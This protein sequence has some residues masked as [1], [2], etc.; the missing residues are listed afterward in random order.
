MKRSPRTGF[1]SEPFDVLSFNQGT[2]SFCRNS[3]TPRGHDLGSIFGFKSG[4]SYQESSLQKVIRTSPIKPFTINSKVSPKLSQKQLRRT[5][6]A[7]KAQYND[8]YPKLVFLSE[9]IPFQKDQ[10]L[11][12][13]DFIMKRHDELDRSRRFMCKHCGK[14]F[15]F[16]PKS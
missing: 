12:L 11:S 9:P 4:T 3:L 6:K 1:F 10:A 15:N 13:I 7:K 5:K 2:A 16:C 8:E 14:R